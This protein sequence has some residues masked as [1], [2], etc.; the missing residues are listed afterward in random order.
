[1]LLFPAVIAELLFGAIRITTLFALIPATGAWGCGALLIRDLVRRGKRGWVSIGLLAAALALAEECVIQQ[2]SFAP[3]VGV[4]PDHAYGRALG[5]NWVYFLWAVGYESVWAVVI[6]IL[7]TELLFSNRREDP[8]LR[9]RGLIIT[10]LVF[11]CASFA[12]WYF[13]TQ[14]FVPQFFPESVYTVPLA[15]TAAACAAIALLVASALGARSVHQFRAPQS[16]QRPWLVGTAGFVVGTLWFM[17]VLLA[18][19]AAPAVPPA[20]PLVSG[21]AIGSAS[22]VAVRRWNERCGWGDVS[23]LALIMGMITASML[24]GFLVLYGS[25]A[26]LIDFVGK[27]V[28]NVLAG[29]ALAAWLVRFSKSPLPTHADEKVGASSSRPLG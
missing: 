15:H 1:L 10:A 20:I 8:W 16:V 11:L 28:L 12:A 22:L 29:S 17:L 7:L 26:P 24:T 3:L 4:N 14:V 9:R 2:T 5:V 13:W 27:A 19:G 21:V 25:A 18:Y 6:P 23:V